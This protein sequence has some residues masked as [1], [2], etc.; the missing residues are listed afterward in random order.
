MR[1]RALVHLGLAALFALCSAGCAGEGS[2]A[3]IGAAIPAGGHP[4][5]AVGARGGGRRPESVPSCSGLGTGAF[6]GG[7]FENVAHGAYSGVLEGNSN[8]V[9]DEES[10]IAGGYYNF[11][12]SGANTS[13][14]AFIGSGYDNSISGNGY[15]SFIGGGNVNSLTSPNSVIAGGNQNTV[16]GADSVIAGGSQNNVSSS[17]TYAAVGGGSANVNGGE[18]GDIGGGASNTLSL[19]GEYGVIGG[20]FS[21]ALSAEYGVI[22]GG[23]SNTLSGEFASIAGGKQN[24]ASGKF[25]TVVG[26]WDNTALGYA[27]FAAGDHA[28]AG[29]E[30]TFVWSDSSSS[31]E[32]TN[33][34]ANSFVARASGGVTFFTNPGDTTGVEVAAGSGTWGSASD[35]ALKTDVASIDDARVLDKVAAL[36]VSEWSY[37]SERG[38]RHVGPMAQD[39]Y[40]AFGVGK[41][42]KHITSIDE[43]GVALAAIKALHS[44]NAALR[45]QLRV[46]QRQ[47]QHVTAM[48]EA[49]RS[50]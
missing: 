31:S 27:S 21:N 43:D 11:I 2:S 13:Y 3:T 24:S 23:F 50:R 12:S 45:R 30:G 37:T 49:L 41:D 46:M 39:F 5:L 16:S 26:G 9:C 19:S 4:A 6:V 8:E 34:V 38:V 18:Y 15:Q 7:G 28:S 33:T 40:A 36:P 1:I 48:V 44:E 17:G 20:G 42:N 35:R 14:Y 22:G 10:S 32:T 29:A 47:V 25:S